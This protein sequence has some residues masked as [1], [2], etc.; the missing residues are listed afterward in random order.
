MKKVVSIFFLMLATWG[1][2]RARSFYLDSKNGNDLADGSTPQKAWKTL[3]KLNQSMSQIQPGDTIFFMRGSIFRESISFLL[4]GSAQKPI[5]LTAAGTGSMPVIN[6]S[7]EL[8]EWNLEGSNVFSA[9]VGNLVKDLYL[10]NLRLTAARYPNQ[11]WLTADEGFGKNGFR[12]NDLNFSDHYWDGAIVRFRPHKWLYETRRVQSYAGRQ[13]A[14]DTPSQYDILTGS[15]YYLENHPAAMDTDFEW[16]YDAA[17]KKVFLRLPSGKQPSSYLIE[18]AIRENGLATNWNLNYIQIRNLKFE[19]FYGS[20]ILGL[21][22]KNSI[23]SGNEVRLCNYGILIYGSEPT[24][25]EVSNNK[26]SDCTAQGISL[27]DALSSIVSSNVVYN[28]GII[29]GYG[30]SGDNGAR[31][32][33]V[34]GISSRNCLVE[35][36]EV[37]SSGYSGITCMGEGHKVQY[38][39]LKNSMLTLSDGGA[40][41][42]WGGYSK[43]LLFANNLISGVEGNDAG[44]PF[45]GKMANAVYLDD[46]V[47]NIT[48]RGNLVEKYSDLGILLHNA[49]YVTVEDN[50]VVGN[51]CL[52]LLYDFEGETKRITSSGNEFFGLHPEAFPLWI[53]SATANLQLSFHDNR[54]INPYNPV[55]VKFKDPTHDLFLGL[56]RWKSEF[57]KDGRSET[58]QYNWNLLEVKDTLSENLVKNGNFDTGTGNWIVWFS[59]QVKT[60]WE[61]SAGMDGGAM[62]L[63]GNSRPSAGYMRTYTSKFPLKKDHTYLVTGSFKASVHTTLYLESENTIT[64]WQYP[65]FSAYLPLVSSERKNFRWVFAMPND[66]YQSDL[67]IQMPW[68]ASGQWLLLDNMGVYEVSATAVSPFSKVFFFTNPSKDRIEYSLKQAKFVDIRG[69]QY[70]GK[71]TLEAWTGKVLILTEGT[72]SM[73]EPPEKAGQILLYPNPVARGQMLTVALTGMDSTYNQIRIVSSSGRIIELFTLASS[74][75]EFFIPTQQLSGG[76]Y[77]LQLLGKEGKREKSFIVVQSK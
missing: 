26:V 11:G 21:G 31:G 70:S 67:Y 59:D 15:G 30:I 43:N 66:D 20:G 51:T 33:Y 18:A 45:R 22:L 5:V 42:T 9:S 34:G 36:N 10:N 39:I 35:L 16:Y 41:Y 44:S 12:D 60:T 65:N 37:D 7:V 8:T 48:V 23:I 77:Y 56:E 46:F 6:G 47:S 74:A 27:I 58:D 62:K 55:K 40:L 71:L 69:K 1:I 38:N 63:T 52:A 4:S 75:G 50:I 2:L 68:H 61:S 14:F 32:I 3:Q 57:G 17:Q 49:D 29:P 25:V 24:A 28:T 19:K 73:E 64:G 54:Y 72:F 53:Q 13:I 76:L